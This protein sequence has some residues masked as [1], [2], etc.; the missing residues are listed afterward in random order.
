MARCDVGELDGCLPREWSKRVNVSVCSKE[1][2]AVTTAYARAGLRETY[3]D[4]VMRLR[5]LCESKERV[6][7]RF[8]CVGGGRADPGRAKG[9]NR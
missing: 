9:A 3:E 5:Q 1:W 7:E 8:Q 6:V 4:D 2:T